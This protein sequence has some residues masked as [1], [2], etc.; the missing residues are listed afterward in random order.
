MSDVQGDG[1]AAGATTRRP[2]R[3]PA[4]LLRLIR[5]FEWTWAKAAV[6]AVVLWAL[7]LTFIAVIPSWFLLFASASWHWGASNVVVLGVKVN[8]FWGAKL[9]DVVGSIL[10]TVPFVVIIATAYKVQVLRQRLRE[11]R[12]AAR[13]GG[14]AGGYR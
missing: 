14:A 8:E 10:F 3:A 13:P 4:G 11:R 5:D 7:A 9:R 2:S 12:P 1:G 6:A